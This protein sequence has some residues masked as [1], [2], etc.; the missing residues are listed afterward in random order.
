MSDVFHTRHSCIYPLCTVS[1]N[2]RLTDHCQAPS[3]GPRPPII[4]MDLSLTLSTFTESLLLPAL[5]NHSLLYPTPLA[6]QRPVFPQD[7]TLPPQAIGVPHRT[8]PTGISRGTEACPIH[9]LVH[10]DT[11]SYLQCENSRASRADETRTYEEHERKMLGT[12]VV[13]ARPSQNFAPSGK[14]YSVMTGERLTAA[15]NRIANEILRGS[16]ARCIRGPARTVIDISSVTRIPRITVSALVRKNHHSNCAQTQ[17]QR[18]GEGLD[19][20]QSKRMVRSILHVCEPCTSTVAIVD[21][22]MMSPCASLKIIVFE[23]RQAIR[24][25]NIRTGTGQLQVLSSQMC[26]TN[27]THGYQ[28]SFQAPI[29]CQCCRSCIA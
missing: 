2:S 19:P 24:A 7:I 8:P 28:V 6:F 4:I 26:F 21:G 16:S 20:E 23:S 17:R 3:D 25:V 10:T 1:K 22:L 12:I 5:K 13:R 27:N 11:S 14:P 18:S 15:Q 9:A 29:C